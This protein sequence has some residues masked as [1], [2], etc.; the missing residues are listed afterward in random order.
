MEDS[1]HNEDFDVE[2]CRKSWEIE[3]HWQLRRDFLVAHMGKYPKDRLLCL[4]QM[5]VNVET[6]GNTYEASLMKEIA[7]L[8]ETV[9]GL[10]TFRIR[11]KE[12]DEGNKFKPTPKPKNNN[13]SYQQNQGGYNKWQGNNQHHQNNQRSNWQSRG[14]ESNN[15]RGGGNGGGGY[16]R[17]G[18]NNRGGGHNY[19]NNRHHPYNNNQEPMY[20]RRPQGNNHPPAYGRRE[21]PPRSYGG[22]PAYGAGAHMEHPPPA[23]GVPPPI[24][25]ASRPFYGQA[26]SFDYGGQGPVCPPVPAAVPQYSTAPHP[27]QHIEST[28]PSYETVSYESVNYS[29]K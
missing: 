24:N 25:L 5:F 7:E 16:Q 19:N 21:E 29:T 4:A 3:D 26:A 23:Y 13:N 10:T 8:A 11:K 20:S 18:G 27:Q 2:A 28:V 17:G 14:G 9:E 15:Y 12:L 1:N 6:M 22:G